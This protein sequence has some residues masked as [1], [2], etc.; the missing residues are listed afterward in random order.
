M[1]KLVQSYKVESTLPITIGNFVKNENGEIIGFYSKKISENL[2]EVI[3]F[4]PLEK[5][6]ADDKFIS[7]PLS[8]SE[9]WENISRCADANPM[10][11]SEVLRL[12][13]A[14]KK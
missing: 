6:I 5:E 9:I 12:Q 14:Y 11:K 2:F 4:G 7:G 13:K 1:K 10:F 8:A 3:L